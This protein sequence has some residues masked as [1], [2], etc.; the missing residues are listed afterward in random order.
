MKI[1]AI[2]IGIFLL[3]GLVGGAF[4]IALAGRADFNELK[5]EIEHVNAENGTL[6][7]RLDQLELGAADLREQLEASHLLIES[8][9]HRIA[10][11]SKQLS[12]FN[13]W[14]EKLAQALPRK[15]PG[16]PGSGLPGP[17][18]GGRAVEVLKEEVK[19]ELKEER[20]EEQ[21]ARYLKWAK[22]SREHE[23]KK[24]RKKMDEE[25]PKFAQKINLNVTQ[26]TSIK[27]IAE[28]VFNQVIEMMEQEIARGEEADWA[29]FSEKVGKIYEETQ[30]E[31]LEMVTEE[32]A[33][34]LNKFF[35]RKE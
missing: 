12:S 7:A 24:W 20:L 26:E 10:E 8:S 18:P 11:L 28:N 1:S 32:Q 35:E 17:L 16:G 22:Q 25:F 6:L 29:A 14:R 9:S 30:A 21:K 31:I 23:T 2:V 4:V 19:R 13:K 15:S 34:K 3:V 27:E 5:S 33:Q